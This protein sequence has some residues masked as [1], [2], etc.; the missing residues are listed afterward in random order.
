MNTGCAI[1]SGTVFHQRFHP[2]RHRFSYAYSMFAIDPDKLKAKAHINWLFGRRWYHLIQFNEKD[3]LGGE[4]DSIK[5]RIVSKVAELGGN[6]D[7]SN[8]IMLV[9]CRSLG[10]YFS[11]INLYYCYDNDG[12]CRWML[13]EVS[14]TP[15]NERH[16]Y[17]VPMG[18]PHK[19]DKAFH[20]SPFMALDMQYH[21]RLTEP[22]E[23]LSVQIENH[24][25]QKMF[26]ASMT[27]TRQPLG[28]NS[29]SASWLTLPFMTLKTVVSIYW[30][31]LKLWLKR[32][33]YI[34]HTKR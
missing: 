14:N 21:W 28:I 33:P 8:V 24:A 17:L 22:D 12:H 18:Q 29:L 19:Q 34:P 20:V 23:H 13:A 4:P 7:G 25:E 5:Q 27:L 15:W 11:P 16:C 2:K 9:Q 1:Y 3:Y 26:I 10:V 30:Q 6:W 32:V 31:A